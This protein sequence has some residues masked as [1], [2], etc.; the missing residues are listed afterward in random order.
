MTDTKLNRRQLIAAAAA[1]GAVLATGPA[2]A[3]ETGAPDLSGKSIL[4]T[5][6]ASGFG[7]LGAQLYAERGA[8]VFATMRNLPRL[9]A[10]N[11]R[12]AAKNGVDLTVLVTTKRLSFQ[13]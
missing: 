6:C 7:Y 2:T 1:T 5:G 4:I 13:A 12:A 10:E 11:L 9:E 3:A 8:K